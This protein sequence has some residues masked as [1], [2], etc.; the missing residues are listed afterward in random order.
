MSEALERVIAQQQQQID[1]LQQINES[2]T[3]SA[4]TVFTREE[5]MFETIARVLGY[6]LRPSWKDD[7]KDEWERYHMLLNELRLQVMEAGF[8]LHCE[9]F[10]CE[11][12]YDE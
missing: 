6:S 4:E 2:L 5:R 7:R 12:D 3:K 8:C 9:R 1:R 11:C 10:V